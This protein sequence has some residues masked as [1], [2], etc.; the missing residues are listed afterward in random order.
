MTEITINIDDEYCKNCKKEIEYLKEL[1]K[2]HK[3][4]YMNMKNYK[5][6][7]GIYLSPDFNS[8]G[9][10]THWHIQKADKSFLQTM[11]KIIESQEKESDAIKK[12]K[13]EMK[14]KNG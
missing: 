8:A 1:Q 13:E 12:V 3:D 2:Q 10:L 9:H 6:L 5:F 11:I 14:K 4:V 7:D